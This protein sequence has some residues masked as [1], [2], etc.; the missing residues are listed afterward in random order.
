MIIRSAIFEADDMVNVP[1]V[2]GPN[3][4]FA[5]SAFALTLLEKLSPALRG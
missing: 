2:A 3:L 1:F 4:S 5:G